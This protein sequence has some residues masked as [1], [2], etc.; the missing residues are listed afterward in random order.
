MMTARILALGAFLVT[1]CVPCYSLAATILGMEFSG[2]GPAAAGGTNTVI[3][4]TFSVSEDCAVSALGLW[5]YGSD[6]FYVSHNVGLYNSGGT[7]LGSV[8]IQ[9]GTGSASQGPLMEGGVFRFEDLASSISLN[10]GSTYTI[11]AHNPSASDVFI[12]TDVDSITM[13]DGLSYGDPRS[14]SAGALTYVTDHQWSSWEGIFGP[15]FQTGQTVPEPSS[16]VLLGTGA[17]CLI[18]YHKRKRRKS[19]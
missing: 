14:A 6:G 8:A 13:A 15:N 1:L 19:A 3:G 9:S 16:F 4:W 17:I 2:G 12:W 18:G 10:S 5:D 7:S 11:L